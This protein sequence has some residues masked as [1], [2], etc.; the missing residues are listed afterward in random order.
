ML[1]HCWKKEEKTQK[2][3]EIATEITENMKDFLK[4]RFC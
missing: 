4:K 2:K 1:E 3:R